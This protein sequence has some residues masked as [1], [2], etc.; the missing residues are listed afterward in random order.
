MTTALQPAADKPL[1]AAAALDKL[2]GDYRFETVLDVGCGAGRHLE[3]FRSAG[4][5]AT[6]IDIVGL[7]K[8]VIVADYLRHEFEQPL[9]CLWLSHVLEHQLN[10]NF[11]LRKVFSDLREGGILAVTVPPLKH[12]IVGGHVTL[13]NAGLVLYNL[14]LA[15][16]D[17]RAARIKQYGYN[18]SVLVPKVP[19][20]VP[21]HELHYDDGDVD[22]LARFFPQHPLLPI[23]Q[24]FSGDIRQLRWDADELELAP[25]KTFGRRIRRL[26]PGAWRAE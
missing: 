11:F 9:D 5:R 19:A 24:G 25:P 22:L 23:R 10:V 14:V 6:G 20:A 21:Y 8:G 16:F 7:S 2:L 18:I 26:F 12:A 1:M 17:C 13:W 15:G 3:R 4:K